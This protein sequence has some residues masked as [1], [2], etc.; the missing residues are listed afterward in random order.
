M[1]SA[2]RVRSRS[3]A[4]SAT[5]VWARSS[6]PASAHPPAASSRR[7]LWQ[8]RELAAGG[9]ALAGELERAQTLVAEKARL[10]EQIGRAHV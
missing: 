9:W 3:R 2:I 6:S 4:F 5:S 10:R 7:Y 8:R 1:S